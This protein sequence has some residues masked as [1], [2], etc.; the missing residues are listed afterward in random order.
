MR[1]G[2]RG[3]ALAGRHAVAKF[4]RSR[5]FL[6]LTRSGLRGGALTGRRA[7]ARSGQRPGSQSHFN[8]RPHR[9][10][11]CRSRLFQAP[12]A[13]GPPRGR[14][15]RAAA[16]RPC[17]ASRSETVLYM[18]AVIVAGAIHEDRAG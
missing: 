2:L 7:V 5:L 1:L 13:L 8:D 11:V 16:G 3:G 6:A 18:K 17:L 9:R 12:L 10:F 14:L 4:F 15:D